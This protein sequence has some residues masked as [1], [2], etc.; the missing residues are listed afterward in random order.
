MTFNYILSSGDRSSLWSVVEYR[1]C[2]LCLRQNDSAARRQTWR[3]PRQPA[4][5]LLGTTGALRNLRPP[6]T[7][8][9][10]V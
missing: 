6:A 5:S 3:V 9:C 10:D 7:E 2:K 8:T 1:Q 4:H